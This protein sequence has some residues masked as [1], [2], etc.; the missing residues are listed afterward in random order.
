MIWSVKAML[1]VSRAA[2]FVALL[3]ILVATE[4]VSARDG[5]MLEDAR[6]SVLFINVDDWNDWNQV[7]RGHPQAITPHIDRLADR[8]VAF[9]NAICS[10]SRCLPSM[11]AIS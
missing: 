11:T 3:W 4:T 5:G 10:S 1:P 7:L 9:C 8:G 6:P 2:V